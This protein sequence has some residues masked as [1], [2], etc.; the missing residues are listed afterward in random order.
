[1]QHWQAVSATHTNQFAAART[2]K[3]T[4]NTP[5]KHALDAASGVEHYVLAH[6]G[7]WRVNKLQ[8][9]GFLLQVALALPLAW[10]LQLAMA[11]WCRTG[12]SDMATKPLA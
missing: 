6:R 5:R 9:D 4:Q 7:H 12:A 2:P 11:C 3:N 1:V 8:G 10:R